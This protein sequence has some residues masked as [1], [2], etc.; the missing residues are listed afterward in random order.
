MQEPRFKDTICGRNDPIVVI[1]YLLGIPLCILQTVLTVLFFMTKPAMLAILYVASGI[2]AIPLSVIL[3]EL[4]KAYLLKNH[5]RALLV[6]DKTYLLILLS[7]D[8]SVRRF[9]YYPIKNNDT[10]TMIIWLVASGVYQFV[11][12]VVIFSMKGVCHLVRFVYYELFS[13]PIRAARN[14]LTQ[15]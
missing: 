10:D 7:V 8:L 5:E 1:M 3:L 12:V 4:I 13:V 2:A 14:E 15:K 6:V 9:F 11:I